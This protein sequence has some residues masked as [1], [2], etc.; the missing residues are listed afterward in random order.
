MSF[1]DHHDPRRYRDAERS[2]NLATRRHFNTSMRH[3]NKRMFCHYAQSHEHIHLVYSR[4]LHGV[5]VLFVELPRVRSTD[6]SM[7]LHETSE[8]RWTA[9]DNV[10]HA[11]LLLELSVITI[12]PLNG[13]MALRGSGSSR[14]VLR[15]LCIN[16]VFPTVS[17]TSKS[18]SHR[19]TYAS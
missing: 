13:W 16:L 3:R 17:L 1:D 14:L 8:R 5:K 11:T 4:S 7:L 9:C 12:T 6:D 19:C 18:P 15:F 10:W 2:S